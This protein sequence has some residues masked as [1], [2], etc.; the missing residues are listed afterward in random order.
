LKSEYDAK[1][2][3]QALKKAG[4]RTDARAETLPLEKA[5]AVYKQL[6]SIEGG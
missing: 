6:T 4:V 1:R 3:Q 5:A 2:I